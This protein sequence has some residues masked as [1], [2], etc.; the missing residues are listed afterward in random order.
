MFLA[1]WKLELLQRFVLSKV[2]IKQYDKVYE[3]GQ[4]GKMLPKDTHKNLR[5]KAMQ[6]GTAQILHKSPIY[7]KDKEIIKKRMTVQWVMFNHNTYS[8]FMCQVNVGKSVDLWTW[9]CMKNLLL[10]IQYT[11]NYL[12]QKTLVSILHGGF[13]LE[14][15]K[16]TMSITKGSL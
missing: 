7:W 8:N 9:E 6:L 13:C 14:C 1:R 10:K 2:K 12:W 5:Q 16:S 3:V 15:H 4:F 11:S